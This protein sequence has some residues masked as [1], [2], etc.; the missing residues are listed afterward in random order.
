M[1]LSSHFPL[2]SPPCSDRFDAGLDG[3]RYTARRALAL[4]PFPG[5]RLPTRQ[6]S[7]QVFLGDMK[8]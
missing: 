5:S 3:G 8:D 2:P 6:A 7:L 1:V 4:S